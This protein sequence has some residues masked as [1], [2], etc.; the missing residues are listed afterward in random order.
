MSPSNPM[1]NNPV[2]QTL[3]EQFFSLFGG[4][5]R[6]YWRSFANLAATILP[7]IA[8]TDAAYHTL[9]HTLQ[10]LQAGQ[11]LLVGRQ[12]HHLDLCPQDWLNVMVALLCH[13]LG[14]RRGICLQDRPQQQ[15]YTTG[16]SDLWIELPAD[17]TD[18]SLTPY[19]VDRSQ[20]FVRDTL[21]HHPLLEV[22]E[23]LRNIEMT[24]FPVPMGAYYQATTTLAGLCRA[25]DLIGQLADPQYLEKLPALF[26]EFAETGTNQALGYQSVL[27]MRASYPHFFW[28]V[29]F[30]YL[31]PHL[32]YLAVTTAGKRAIAR[33]YTNVYRVELEQRRGDTT[34]P[35][36]RQQLAQNQLLPYSAAIANPELFPS[37]TE[38]TSLGTINFDA[39]DLGSM[40]S[41][42]LC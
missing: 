11:W 13:D 8:E 23:I 38:P 15:Q 37:V 17:A 22:E 3:E 39:L 26:Q 30:P 12:T 4:S 5:A 14:Y 31:R 36:L 32:P 40:D 21:S 19:H 10:V 41:N 29:V 2:L 18:A 42:D 27:D 33:L 16:Q 24:R 34:S 7:A 1:A 20:Q 9:D 6:S 25:A 28:Q 35:L